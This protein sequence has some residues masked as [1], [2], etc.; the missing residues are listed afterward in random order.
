[1]G[2]QQLKRRVVLGI[3]MGL[4]IIAGW[5]V[6][7]TERQHRLNEAVWSQLQ[8]YYAELETDFPKT[9]AV[10]AQPPCSDSD[11][12]QDA[13]YM[14]KW[15]TTSSVFLTQLVAERTTLA[16]QG[17]RIEQEP[18]PPTTTAQ[19]YRKGIQLKASKAW[20]GRKIDIAFLGG[21][22]PKTSISYEVFFILTG[23]VQNC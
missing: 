17:W 9:S 12:N 1:M 15:R 16:R 22:A 14:S 19:N 18:Q 5:H 8:T 20:R 21:P 23:E 10:E 3:A 13:Q 6:V 4:A 2:Q 11:P 7:H